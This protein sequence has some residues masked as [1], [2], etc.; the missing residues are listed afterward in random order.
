MKDEVLCRRYM[1]SVIIRNPYDKIMMK[2]D[3]ECVKYMSP[4]EMNQ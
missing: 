1:F 4:S 2:M 3:S